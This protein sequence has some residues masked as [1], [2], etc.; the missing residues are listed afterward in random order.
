[1]VCS[2]QL[3]VIPL[4]SDHKVLTQVA[5]HGSHTIKLLPALNI[6][7]EDCAWIERSFESVIAGAHRTTGAV[8]RLGRTLVKNAVRASAA[9]PP[10]D[11]GRVMVSDQVMG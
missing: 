2:A 3:I 4:F 6:T 10:R 1:M 7:D 11:Q 5:G 9:A 8:W